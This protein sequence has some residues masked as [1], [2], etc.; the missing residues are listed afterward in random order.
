M[1]T[2]HAIQLT[3]P[4]RELRMKLLSTCPLFFIPVFISLPW[5]SPIFL[6]RPGIWKY[7]K[8]SQY[9]SHQTLLS[10]IIF[11]SLESSLNVEKPV[12]VRIYTQL[13]NRA[14]LGKTWIE[15]RVEKEEAYDRWDHCR[16]PS[17]NRKQLPLLS[18]EF[19]SSL[20]RIWI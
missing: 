6:P 10:S 20:V 14:S 9:P 4:F 16:W 1:S 7:W 5:R 17:F 13:T 15:I 18:G 8:E 11:S 3:H 2:N 12:F 19:L